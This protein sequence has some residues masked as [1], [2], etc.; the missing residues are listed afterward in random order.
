[1]SY[2][3]L[4]PTA[5]YGHKAEPHFK[6]AQTIPSARSERQRA[7]AQHASNNCNTKCKEVIGRIRVA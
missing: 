6:R 4:E 1:V 2:Y 7:V 5:S 3:R